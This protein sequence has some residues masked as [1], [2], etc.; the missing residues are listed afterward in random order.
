MTGTND[1]RSVEM[2]KTALARPVGRL[3]GGF[4]FR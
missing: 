2:N 3:V 1:G 4:F